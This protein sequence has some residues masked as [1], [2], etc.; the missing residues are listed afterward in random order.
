MRGKIGIMFWFRFNINLGPNK[1]KILDMKRPGETGTLKENTG[2]IMTKNQK[3][4]RGKSTTMKVLISIQRN[5]I[6]S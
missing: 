2:E 3:G 6:K 5:I 1:G 4:T